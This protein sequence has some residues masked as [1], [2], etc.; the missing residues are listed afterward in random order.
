MHVYTYVYCNSYTKPFT[1][2]GVEGAGLPVAVGAR[3][4]F[5]WSA[6]PDLAHNL[7]VMPS[8]YCTLPCLPPCLLLATINHH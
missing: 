1:D 4:H 3:L 5:G 7:M 8:G 6:W 2:V